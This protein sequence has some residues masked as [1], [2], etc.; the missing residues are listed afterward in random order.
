MSINRT[1]LD[2]LRQSLIYQFLSN[3]ISGEIISQT[4]LLVEQGRCDPNSI[5]N[6][7]A[8]RQLCIHWNS[9]L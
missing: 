4:E 9:S 1:A 2:P 8:H 6:Q 7:D 3:L 5:R